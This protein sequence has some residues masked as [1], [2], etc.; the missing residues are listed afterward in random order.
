MIINEI[1]ETIKFISKIKD[2]IEDVKAIVDTVYSIF[3]I[4][5]QIK[6]FAEFVNLIIGMFCFIELFCLIHFIYKKLIFKRQN[7][8]FFFH[9][10]IRCF[11]RKENDMT[12]LVIKTLLTL[13]VTMIVSTG[14]NSV[15]QT[16]NKNIQTVAEAKQA[17]EAKKA[18]ELKKAEEAQKATAQ[19]TRR[20]ATAVRTQAQAPAPVTESYNLPVP[21]IMQNPELP[22]GCEVTSLT[23]VMNYKG[24]GVDKCTMADYYLPKGQGDPNS[25]FIG[26]PRDN[27]GWYCFA[28]VLQQ[29]VNNYNASNG[30]G[31]STQNL[32]GSDVSAL[33]NQIRNGNPV[34]V[35]ITLRY[36]SPRYARNGRYSNLHCIVLSGFDDNNVYTTDPIY[37]KQTINRGTFES[38]WNA[39]GR[40]AMVIN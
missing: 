26:N 10:E 32:S 9:I 11:K 21:L 1:I 40:R 2:V 5:P 18:E 29:T 16:A 7:Y 39:M 3:L 14:N 23:E 22:N 8:E 6:T 31:I 25:V 19:T 4:I 13:A 28:P 15:L 36:Q 24:Y 17:E 37:G 33:Y 38:V 35:W 30:T 34:V 20:R 27:T 12:K